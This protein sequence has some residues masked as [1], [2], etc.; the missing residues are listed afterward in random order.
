MI[1]SKE[2]KLYYRIFLFIGATVFLLG[3][4]NSTKTKN[5]SIDSNQ[6]QSATDHHMGTDSLSQYWVQY[7]FND[8][9]LIKDPNQGEQRF[10]DFIAAFPQYSITTVSNAI[11]EM[12]K[13]AEVNAT[14]FQFFKEKYAHYLYD[15]NSPMRNEWYYEPVLTYLVQSPSSTDTDKIRYK[16]QLDMVRKNQPGTTITDFQYLTSTGKKEKLHDSQG[17]MRL[18]VFYD[19]T[20]SHCKEIIGTL[21]TS[22]L[23]NSFIAK[24]Q[25]KVIAIDPLG[26]QNL[27]KD[28][29]PGIPSNWTNGFD[30]RDVLI[31]KQLYSLSA[32]PTLYVIDANNNVISKDPDYQ[33]AL[34]IL[35]RHLNV[36]K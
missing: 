4:Q 36:V 14:V 18:I 10:V 32:Y 2:H 35:D 5:Q 17:L 8:T 34:N 28:Y 3:C 25:I 11:T 1:F 33:I 29:Q 6:Q 9:L 21:K 15:P 24:K 13:K 19:P 27:W 30:D 7:N 31:K 16:M 26:D 22:E 23:L 20:C 12:L